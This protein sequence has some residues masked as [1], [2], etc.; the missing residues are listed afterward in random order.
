[1][2][3]ARAERAWTWLCRG[4]AVAG[5]GVTLVAWVSGQVIPAFWPI[6]LLALFFGPEIVK[7]QIQV[8]RR[9][10]GDD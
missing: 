10:N 9:K 8:N 3:G 2:N 6:L 4:L 7:G 1:M 5:F